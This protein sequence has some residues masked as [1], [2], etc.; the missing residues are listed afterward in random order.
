MLWA[1]GWGTARLARI[2]YCEGAKMSLMG[3][4]NKLRRLIGSMEAVCEAKGRM[5]VNGAVASERTFRMQIDV[6]KQFARTLHEK[7]F[8]L[9]SCEN[10]GEKHINAVFDAW[11]H[12]R[13]L[14][15]K[16]LQ[17]Q[18]SRVK[19][20]MHWLGKPNLADYVRQ[21]DGRYAEKLPQG[22]RVK[23]VADESKSWRGA[24]VDLDELFRKA[25]AL[26]SRYAA[27]LMLERAFGLRKKEVLLIKLWKADKGDKLELV[28]E[29]TKN[30]RYR[31]VAIREGE[32]GQMQREI[33][34]YAKGKCRRWES[35]AWPDVTLAQAEQR[36]YGLNRQLGLTKKDM[37]MTG[38]GL[39]AGH[40]EDIMLLRGGRIAIDPG[41]YKR[42]GKRYGANRC[43]V[44]R[45]KDAGAQQRDHHVGVHRDGEQQTQGECIAGPPIWRADRRIW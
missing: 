1:K 40:A 2:F 26:D 38:H 25:K 17:N 32:Y 42:H 8:M 27:M 6:M 13:G 20:F 37:G 43:A 16:T 14:S 29:I 23:T 39:R 24:Q 19:Q 31:E 28:G 45:V 34:D 44:R 12:E 9:E 18:K 11:V 33:L 36:Y 41:R 15:N 3:D 4:G 22:F 10:L 30:G 7:G 35:M 5:R 21:V